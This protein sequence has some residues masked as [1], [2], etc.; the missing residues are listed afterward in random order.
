VSSITAVFVP[1]SGIIAFVM[2][3]FSHLLHA[4]LPAGRQSQ[5]GSHLE[6]LQE[7]IRG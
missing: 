3:P 2:L 5:Q 6:D 1:H 7:D 4:G